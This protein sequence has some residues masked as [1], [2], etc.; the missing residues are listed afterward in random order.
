M[1]SRVKKCFIHLVKLFRKRHE[2]YIIPWAI[3][4]KS[5][6][7]AIP[8]IPISK[9]HF[10]FD[11]TTSKHLFLKLN[12]HLLAVKIFPNFHLIFATDT[13]SFQIRKLLIELICITSGAALPFLTSSIVLPR[14]CF[15]ILIYWAT[16]LFFCV[17]RGKLNG[18]FR[19]KVL[20][21]L[22]KNFKIL[23]ISIEKWEFLT[24][25]YWQPRNH[26]ALARDNDF[27]T[28]FSFWF[29]ST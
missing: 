3:A 23:T 5:N 16:R 6:F 11:A 26:L 17:V 4:V 19:G 13:S 7:G 24:K 25:L 10:W 28:V 20:W 12:T 8:F 14:V 21:I 22:F 9:I 27:L 15:G 2:N 29:F 1:N 18:Y